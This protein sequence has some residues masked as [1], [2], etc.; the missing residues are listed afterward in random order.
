MAAAF[1]LLS[2]CACPVIALVMDTPTGAVNQCETVQLSWSGGVAPYY[3]DVTA[4]DTAFLIEMLDPVGTRATSG[5]WLVSVAAGTQI[6]FEIYD[7]AGSSNISSIVTVGG[8]SDAS[9]LGQISFAPS[10]DNVYT[11]E[12]T[13]AGMSTGVRTTT[14]ASATPT[15][16]SQTQSSTITSSAVTSV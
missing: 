3:P 15:A 16:T 12:T 9:C 11:S 4:T 2:I 8:G 6:I 10:G 13:V 7:A 5:T 14:A 1:A